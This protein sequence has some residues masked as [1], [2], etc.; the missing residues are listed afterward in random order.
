MVNWLKTSLKWLKP[1]LQD[2]K[3]F[4]CH[5]II[6]FAL[7]GHLDEH[8]VSALKPDLGI[9]TVLER[10]VSVARSMQITCNIEESKNICGNFCGLYYVTPNLIHV[11]AVV[12]AD[13]Q[14]T[15]INFSNW[16]CNLFKKIGVKFPMDK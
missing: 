1:F 13:S 11:L 3:Y 8:L 9:N 5:Y 16:A 14:N 10:S 12:L 7:Q 15:C 4:G 6:H 2:D